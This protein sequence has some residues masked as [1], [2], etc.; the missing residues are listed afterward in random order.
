MVV[1]LTLLP[2]PRAAGSVRVKREIRYWLEHKPEGPASFGPS[3]VDRV[4][5]LSDVHYRL[6]RVGGPPSAGDQETG[7]K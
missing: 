3:V 5:R 1:V 6:V 2:R 4:A 7:Y